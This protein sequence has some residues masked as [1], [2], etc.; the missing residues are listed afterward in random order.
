MSDQVE[1]IKM[2][3]LTADDNF[4]CRGKIVPFDV[5]NLAADIKRQ[6]LI[7]PI[8]VRPRPEGGYAVVAGFRRYYAHKLN[9]AEVISCI[10]REHLTEADAKIL[11]LSENLQRKDLNMIQEANAIRGLRLEGLTEQQLAD[12]LGVS[13]TWVQV[14]LD[15][16]GLPE[17]VQKM[18]A[19]GIF[20]QTHIRDLARMSES[21]LIEAVHRAKALQSNVNNRELLVKR[22]NDPSRATA[23]N[24]VACFAMQDHIRK[25]IGNNLATRTLAWAAG[26]ISTVE[27][28]LTLKEH[29]QSVGRKYIDSNI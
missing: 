6:G 25:H 14:R 28:E 5:L 4:N 9:K 8:V 2:A 16:L 26:E 17:E 23:R 22:K 13:R 11:N 24:R 27:F 29:G 18:A 3:D 21:E 20:N 7:S 15:L 19:A 10:V 1:Q 12:R